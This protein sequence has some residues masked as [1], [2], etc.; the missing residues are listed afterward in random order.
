MSKKKKEYTYLKVTSETLYFFETGSINNWNTQMVI[1]DWFHRFPLN[2]FHASRDSHRV[3]Y[4][5][6]LIDVKEVS[7]ADLT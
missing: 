2:M 4:S 6:K 3:G 5:T 7:E 1:E